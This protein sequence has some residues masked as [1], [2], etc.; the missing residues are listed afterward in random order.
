[1]HENSSRKVK[2]MN[3]AQRQ[4]GTMGIDFKQFLKL[5]SLPMEWSIVSRPLWVPRLE[6]FPGNNLR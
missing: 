1:M 3:R 2:P 4:M 6:L 5:H